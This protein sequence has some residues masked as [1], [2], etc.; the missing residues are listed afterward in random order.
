M[1]ATYIFRWIS[2]QFI[3]KTICP[4]IDAW[5]CKL[6]RKLFSELLHIF[7]L[8]LCDNCSYNHIYV[9]WFWFCSINNLMLIK[10]FAAHVSWMSIDDLIKYCWQLCKNSL[11]KLVGT[12][13]L[14]SQF[15]MKFII[16]YLKY[17]HSSPGRTYPFPL[18][19]SGLCGALR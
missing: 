15:L 2:M 1:T 14:W 19:E 7:Q 6:F 18:Y 3:N 8:N 17:R 16:Y 4:Y 13:E 10:K 11:Y 5:L 12:T 9:Q